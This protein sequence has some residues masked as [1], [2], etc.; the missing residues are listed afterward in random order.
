M[1]AIP[2][3]CH[4]TNHVKETKMNLPKFVY[5]LVITSEKSLF[6][7]SCFIS[8]SATKRI[9]PEAH[10]ALCV[11][12]PTHELLK[13]HAQHL[14]DL[15][16]EVLSISPFGKTARERSRWVKVQM[17]TIVT[18]DYIYIDS[19]A[20]PIKPIP[21]L[22]SHD[23]DFMAAI[24]VN[25]MSPI[26]FSYFKEYCD[27]LGWKYNTEHYF[28]S[29]VHFMR[30][31][32]RT[33]DFGAGWQAKWREYIK[34]ERSGYNA[35]QPAFNSAIHEAALTYIVADPKFN[36]FL[37]NPE[38]ATEDQ[39]ILHF[40]QSILEIRFSSLLSNLIRRYRKTGEIDWSLIDRVKDS[41][42]P[43][44]MPAWLVKL[45]YKYSIARQRFIKQ[46]RRLLPVKFR[47]F[48]VR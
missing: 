33:Q 2:A 22:Y 6:V 47:R 19:D 36:V 28:N 3:K 17:R 44:L 24:D 20:L 9:Y 29:G 8:M 14:L 34:I 23:K 1:I 26:L 35:D 30:D 10:I 25:A 7:D 46:F 18:G 31:N 38:K 5:A 40:P 11:D 45:E 15:C 12:E 43:W 13:V 39:R 4:K 21:E 48:L 37:T 32:Q 27:K 16:S 42:Y 41:D